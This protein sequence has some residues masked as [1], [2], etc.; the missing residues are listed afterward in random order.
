MKK[1]SLFTFLILVLLAGCK[2]ADLAGDEVTGEGLVG[3]AI[4]S[5]VSGTEVILNAATPSAPIE[6]TWSEAK[7]GLNTKPTYTFLA[8][9]KTTGTFE[10]PLIQVP[11]DNAGLDTKLTLTHKQLDDALK[12]KGIADG[13][14]AELTWTIK[15]DNG[16]TVILAS[17]V[18][19]ITVT[20]FKDGASPFI[21]LA[22]ASSTTPVAI[23]PGST[24]QSI[25]FR[26]TRSFP[27]AGGPAVSYRVLFSPEGNF[28]S[29][30]FSLTPNPAPAD[31]TA[32][33]SYKALSDTLTAKGLTNLSAPTAL[34]WT[35]VATSGSWRQQAD[36]VNDIAVLREVRLY[37]PGNYQTATGNGADWTPANAP[38]LLRDLRPGLANNLYYTYIY[39]PAN[40]EFKITQGR[41]WDVNYGGTGGNLV[42]NSSDNIKV[43]TAGVYR[44]SVNRTTLKYNVMAGRMGFVGGATAAGWTPANVFPNNALSFIGTNLFLGIADFTADEW[45]LIDNNEWNNG[46]NTPD[47]TRSYGTK[48]GNILSV[49]G[50]NFATVNPPGRYRVIWD[51]RDS[52]A[53]KYDMTAAAQMRVVGDGMDVPGVND[54]DPGSS[55]QMNYLGQGRWQI[56]LSLKAGKDIKFLAGN[57]WGAFDYEDNGDNGSTGSNTNR[58]LKWDGGG[59][60]KTPAVAGTYTI[61]LDEYAQTMQINP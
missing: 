43:T 2:K 15:A 7:P 41:T 56:R 6:I 4:K 44:V 60:F 26:W 5:P 36:F 39:L 9:Q 55:P 16:S 61:I 27:A 24:T 1:L 8:T 38:E 12:A 53:L 22:P 23:D 54:W 14:K 48:T 29:P 25:T 37:M 34:K 46:S 32:S 47:D 10:V 20:R 57:A 28:S 51:G 58:K 21:L 59:N 42:L 13:A 50:D 17:N 35:V 11:A 31:T 40:A 33:I 45:K 49:N 18:F 19:N 52:S 3:F 30:L